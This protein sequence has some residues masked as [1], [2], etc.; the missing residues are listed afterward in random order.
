[1]KEFRLIDYTPTEEDLMRERA[2]KMSA[3]DYFHE[4]TRRNY[5]ERQKNSEAWLDE[6]YPFHYEVYKRWLCG[7]EYKTIAHYVG[8]SILDAFKIV[9]IYKRQ[10]LG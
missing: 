10:N 4:E 3:A 8:C 1:M 7:Y 2:A 9:K 6:N 5:N